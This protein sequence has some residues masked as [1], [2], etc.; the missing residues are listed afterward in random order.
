MVRS[1]PA[2]RDDA[3]MPT[4]P[5]I[6]SISLLLVSPTTSLEEGLYLVPCILLLVLPFDKVLPMFLCVDSSGDD[7]STRRPPRPG[8]C[9]GSDGKGE[10]EPEP[11]PESD[12]PRGIPLSSPAES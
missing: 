2:V 7:R 9:N 4:G 10:S 12:D 6:S 8:K 3:T 11:E 5:D 1:F